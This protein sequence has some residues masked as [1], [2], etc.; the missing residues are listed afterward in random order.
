MNRILL[1]VLLV[2]MNASAWASDIDIIRNAV[3]TKFM[4]SSQG[5]VV[6]VAVNND[7]I[8]IRATPNSSNDKIL[9]I[10]V[11]VALNRIDAKIKKW[12][13]VSIKCS[14]KDYFFNRKSFDLYR[15]GEIN[16]RKFLSMVSLKG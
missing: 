10:D 15:R 13:K 14:K 12:S 16:D 9:I 4:E 3:S 11:A 5:V 8:V 7:L 1:M 6:S 2:I